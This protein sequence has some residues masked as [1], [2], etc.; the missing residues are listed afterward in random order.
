[1]LANIS[2]IITLT[3]VVIPHLQR[4]GQGHAE[5]RHPVSLQQYV[6][7]QLLPGLQDWLEVS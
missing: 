6:A 1:M 3:P 2:K 7:G 4:V 5:L